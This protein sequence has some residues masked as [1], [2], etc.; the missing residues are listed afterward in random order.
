MTNEFSVYYTSSEA[1]GSITEC[2]C[3]HVDAD[4]AKKWFLHHSTNACAM[5]GF[6]AR[7]IVTD[8]GDCIVAEWKYGKGITWPPE[9]GEE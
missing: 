4:E 9:E 3:K 7:V 8:A 1:L 6:T 2:E 5:A